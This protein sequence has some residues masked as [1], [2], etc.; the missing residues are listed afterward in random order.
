MQPGMEH[1]P[2]HTWALL[3]SHL[4]SPHGFSKLNNYL[5]SPYDFHKTVLYHGTDKLVKQ[6]L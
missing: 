3:L 2:F 4:Q 1:T 5:I 6:G